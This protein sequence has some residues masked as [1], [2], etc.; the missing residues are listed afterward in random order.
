MGTE[1]ADYL[2]ID[3]DGVDMLAKLANVLNTTAASAAMDTDTGATTEPTNT[4]SRTNNGVRMRITVVISYRT[5]K[6]RH[7]I[8][9]WHQNSLR[10]SDPGLYD[11]INTT[12]HGLGTLDAALGMADLILRHPISQRW[13]VVLVDLSGVKEDGWDLSNLIACEVL[14]AECDD[15]TKG[16]VKLRG[17]A[18]PFLKNAKKYK[19][20]ID[21]SDEA[22]ERIE[23]VLRGYDCNY[24]HLFFDN[25]GKYAKRLQILHPFDLERIMEDCRNRTV[26][27]PSSRKVMKE[28]IV[29]IVRSSEKIIGLK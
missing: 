25:N 2:T 3:S 4:T 18:V 13:D 10:R 23:G 26:P 5:P 16:P 14:R 21:V 27:Y 20:P 29:K 7:L 8:S 15:E 19:K 1:A 9:V 17:G 11:W 22:L 6:A 24:Q 28:E 12:S